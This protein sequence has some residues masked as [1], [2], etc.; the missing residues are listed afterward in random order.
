MTLK[1]SIRTEFLL[2]GV[3]AQLRRCS[4]GPAL[5]YHH[6]DLIRSLPSR[7]WVVVVVSLFVLEAPIHAESDTAE[8]WRKEG[9]PMIQ[10]LCLD[11]HNDEYQ[12]AELSLSGYE[13]LDDMRGS[14]G[15]MQRVLEMVRFGAMPPEDYALPTVDE[16]KRLTELLDQSLY[17][18]SC[19]LRPRPGK[20]T[21]RRLNRGEYNRTVSD[22]F[23]FP[24]DVANRFP[25]DEVGAG[26]D[27]NGDVLSLSPLMIEKYLEAA[28]DISRQVLIDPETLPRVEAH[29]PSD[30]MIVHGP[31]DFGSFN[32]LFFNNETLIWAE[33]D[34]PTSGEYLIKVRG[35]RSSQ[36]ATDESLAIYDEGGELIVCKEI[37]YYGGGGSSQSFD[38]KLDLKKGQRKLFVRLADDNDKKA[39]LDDSVVRSDR[40]QISEDDRR[41][42]YENAKKVPVP[43][44]RLS[45]DEFPIM[46]RSLDVFG[47][48]R[49]P[50]ELLPPSQWK[51]IRK[52][53]RHRRDRWYDV[54]P[55]AIECLKPL[56]RRAFRRPVDDE[57]V[58]RYAGLVTGAT[59]RGESFYR[60]MQ[61][62]VSAVLVSPSFLFRIE[63]PPED[64]ADA[65]EPVPLT[66]HQLASRLSYFLWSSTPDEWLL[67]EADKD[68]ISEKKLPSIVQRMLSSPKSESLATEFATQWLGLRNLDV[69]EADT[70]RFEA[71]TPTLRNAMKRETQLVFAEALKNN[72]PVADLLT[73]DQTFVN[74]ELADFYG[75]DFSGED[76]F[77]KVSL[78]DSSRRGILSHA[79][80]LTFTSN[81][82]R[83]S[84]V[85]RGKWILENVLGTP[86]PDPPA[87]VP[88]LD[89]P[90]TAH[91]GASLREQLEIHRADPACAAC[92]R[93]MDQLGFGLEAYDAIGRFRNDKQ[94]NA[95]DSSGVLP[96]GREFEGP[97]ELAE[98]LGRTEA[99][100]FAKTFTER[101]MTFA[102]G[103]ELR[104]SD[105]CVIDA[106]VAKTADNG[107]RMADIV[108]EVVLSETFRYYDWEPTELTAQRNQ[109]DENP[110][111]VQR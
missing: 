93:V 26:F 89:E 19:D 109:T 50:E 111:S 54:E 60:G 84:P 106:V 103:R 16:R 107:F 53:P 66:S 32:G 78:S 5:K 13:T 9:W 4:R 91:E 48:T 46:I 96:G 65:T 86:P 90:E 22:L 2:P 68:K 45:R 59:E 95:V 97:A 77:K 94:D 88:E 81:P 42:A 17:S 47:P 40:I 73:L 44:R 74:Q 87:G 51:I 41:L 14:E 69:H 25:S 82:D 21:A 70:S 43:N 30:Q 37:N 28:E 29:R 55:A 108:S 7:S 35:G 39:S 8:A 24:I 100:A 92:H 64:V 72:L 20:V 27:N 49:T 57:E 76:D 75:L 80:I 98:V 67:S 105:R 36:N 3:A 61:I 62:A 85:Q 52:T 23:G 56:M 12:E 38:F 99:A 79:G 63:H 6:V 104:P 71:F 58:E 18:V 33:Y 83:T 102:L 110:R 11:C 10:E 34:I 101:L 15:A 31:S 1:L